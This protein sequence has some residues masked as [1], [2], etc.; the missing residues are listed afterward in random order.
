MISHAADSDQALGGSTQRHVARCTACRQFHESCQSLGQRLRDEAARA[1]NA[2][3]QQ[4][5]RILAAVGDR[6]GRA[7]RVHVPARMAAAAC[8]AAALLIAGA[9][10]V[11][12]SGPPESPPGLT[13]LPA[14]PNV[15]L[16]RVMQNPLE[17]EM[18]NLTADTESGVRFLV[19][20]L[21]VSPAPGAAHEG[22]S[23]P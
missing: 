17:T 16:A 22:R 5:Q 8:L 18:K 20:C 13:R 23:R 3:E 1:G 15:D 6:P 21:D 12:R 4:T 2:S 14:P 11:D 10:L 19:A 7:Q 9:L